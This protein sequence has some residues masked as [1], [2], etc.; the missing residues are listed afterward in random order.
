MPGFPFDDFL[1]RIPVHRI[2]L[3]FEGN[4]ATFFINSDTGINERLFLV[5]LAS[6]NQ[7]VGAEGVRCLHDFFLIGLEINRILSSHFVSPA[8]S[9]PFRIH[10]ENVKNN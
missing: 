5:V 9:N 10:S 1:F 3:L 8:R 2:D 7:E 4:F 6:T